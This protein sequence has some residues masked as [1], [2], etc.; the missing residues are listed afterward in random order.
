M[1]KGVQHPMRGLFLRNYLSHA[2]RELL[3]DT[4]SEYS[5][6]GGGTVHDS[7]EFIITNFSETNRLWVRMQSQVC[8]CGRGLLLIHLKKK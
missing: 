1:T 4:G 2:A 7:L 8:V 6:G 5:E 3:P